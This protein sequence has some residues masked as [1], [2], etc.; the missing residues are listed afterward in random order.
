ML[1][2]I[3]IFDNV[4]VIRPPRPI[5]R[6]VYLCDKKFHVEDLIPLYDENKEKY[7]VVI[8]TGEGSKYYLLS[9][10]EI[11]HLCQH[12]VRLP[13]NQKKGGQSAPR[14]GRIRDGD[15][16]RYITSV[17][18]K[19]I[20]CYT[21][22]DLP[23]VNG[24][25]LAGYADKRDKVYDILHDKLKQ[26]CQKLTINDRDNIYT[27]QERC[28][29]LFNNKGD[30]RLQEFYKNIDNGKATYGSNDIMI[31]KLEH[32]LL[33]KLFIYEDLI[34]NNIIEK[35]EAVGCQ[36]VKIRNIDDKDGAFNTGY[37]GIAGIK[38]F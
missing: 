25:V 21:K 23:I 32:A 18:E 33:E 11:R 37:G 27:I 13:K 15:I 20:K 5:R 29:Q 16:H 6:N 22:D 26:S 34:D 2:Q 8:I 24:L 36:L 35:C 28:L 30:D 7:G 3:V 10:T 14:I 38:W 31:Q 4:V 17:G 19:C 1:V 12:E 9:G